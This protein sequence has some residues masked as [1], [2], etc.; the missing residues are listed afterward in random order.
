[1]VFCG[2][3]AH[4]MPSAHTIPPSAHAVCH[5]WRTKAAVKFY[6]M[7][8]ANTAIDTIARWIMNFVIMH[9]ESIQCCQIFHNSYI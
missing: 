6:D 8:Q 5:G 4:T 7:E 3:T 1:M 9:E 2:T